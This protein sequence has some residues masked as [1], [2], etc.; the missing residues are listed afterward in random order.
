[1][2]TKQID[3]NQANEA[4]LQFV[5]YA[6]SAPS[7]DNSQPWV[8]SIADDQVD[9]QYRHRGNA[10]DVFGENGH[11]TILAAGALQENID[12]LLACHGLPSSQR[13]LEHGWRL[14]FSAPQVPLTPN[15]SLSTMLNRHTNRRSFAPAPPV[16]LKGLPESPNKSCRTLSV[17]QPFAIKTIAKAFRLCSEARFN[18]KILHEWLFSSLRWDKASIESGD[19]LDL[20][21]IDL[22]Q[23]GQHFMRLISPWERM[24]FF[25]K[26][27]LYKLLAI[28]DSLPVSQASCV[29]A[30]IGG[31]SK[32]DVWDSG[33]HL[34]RTWIELNQR[35]LAVHPYYAVTDLSNRLGSG[36][37]DPFWATRVRFAQD[38]IAELLQLTENE[39][40]HMLLRVGKPTTCAIR[41]KRR[42]AETFIQQGSFG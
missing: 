40:L 2:T 17:V 42:P 26:L 7:A 11:G 35:G 16:A 30:I 39:Q 25:N 14:L 21:T 6:V 3:D 19:G 10:T 22:P 20:N 27:G 29:I 37:I 18:S 38:Q 8:F 13:T 31:R 1:M 41:S 24:R 32:N 4:L 9:C 5:E 28:A 33:K 12:R 23:G 34:Q 15:P 36:L